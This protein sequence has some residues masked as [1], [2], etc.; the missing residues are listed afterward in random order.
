MYVSPCSKLIEQYFVK[1]VSCD[2]C[3]ASCEMAEVSYETRLEPNTTC[4]P[5][6]EGTRAELGQTPCGI[7]AYYRHCWFRGLELVVTSG[8]NLAIGKDHYGIVK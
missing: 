1:A 8:G 2:L 3:G 7:I 5:G 6:C 4:L